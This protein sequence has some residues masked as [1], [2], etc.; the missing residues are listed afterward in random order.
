VTLSDN[1]HYSDRREYLI[2]AVRKRRKKVR[3]MAIDHK[4]GRCQICGYERCPEALEFH[5]LD[6]TGKDFGISDKG[7]TRSWSRIKQEIEKCLLLCANCHREV[8][9]GL[10]LPREIVVEKSGELKEACL[11]YVTE[12]GNPEP[13]PDRAEPVREGAETRAEART[14]GNAWGKRP[15]PSLR[16]NEAGDEIVQAQKKFWGSCNH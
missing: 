3:Q 8:H 7:Y 16:L 4:G 11:P 9:S 5:H 1:R 13:S 15:T 14:L 6:E 10:Q 2:E 12:N